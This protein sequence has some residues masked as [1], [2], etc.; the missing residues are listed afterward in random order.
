MSDQSG[1]VQIQ[2]DGREFVLRPSLDAIRR[3]QGRGI[4]LMP[5]LMSFKDMS[6]GLEELALLVWAGVNAEGSKKL[7]IQDAEELVF[8]TGFNDQD[9]LNS[10]LVF[11]TNMTS[12]GRKAKGSEE[13]DE[14]SPT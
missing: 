8:K 9:M 12:G 3:L 2:L 11:V 1:E 10:I 14:D 5:L 7:S 6:Y 4:K 13:V